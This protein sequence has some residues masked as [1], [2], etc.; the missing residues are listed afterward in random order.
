M[1]LGLVSHSCWLLYKYQIKKAFQEEFLRSWVELCESF[2]FVFLMALFMWLYYFALHKECSASG[3]D[4]EL[5]LDV[6]MIGLFP[7]N[8]WYVKCQ[9]LGKESRC[10]EVFS[11]CS[12]NGNGAAV[13]C[14]GW[15]KSYRWK[16]LD[17]GFIAL[18]ITKFTFN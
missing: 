18:W 1:L 3:D 15:I 9:K 14:R 2:H 13:V 16:R 6:V 4:V 7:C 11:S 17:E 5:F 10:S 8:Q 12:W